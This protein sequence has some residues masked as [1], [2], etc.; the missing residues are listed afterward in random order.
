MR[1]K[2]PDERDGVTQKF[3]LIARKFGDDGAPLDGVRELKGYI[4]ASVYPATRP[5]GTP[6]PMAGKLGEVLVKVGKPGE[7]TALLDA[8][9]IEISKALQRGE[10]PVALFSKHRFT[11]FEPS[12]AVRGVKGITRCSSPTDLVSNWIGRRFLGITDEKE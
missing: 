5:D 10:N 11:Q 3:T 4:T 12:G 9:A 7:E 6:H 8:W 2:L 1:E